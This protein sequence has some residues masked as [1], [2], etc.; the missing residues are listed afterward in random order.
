[1]EVNENTIESEESSLMEALDRSKMHDNSVISS[2][3]EYIP[4]GYE[5]PAEQQGTRSV[6]VWIISDILCR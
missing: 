2:E 4:D 5:T 6:I 3:L 1:M